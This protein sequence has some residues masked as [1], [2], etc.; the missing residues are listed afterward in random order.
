MVILK[1]RPA[2]DQRKQPHVE[3]HRLQLTL[4]PIVHQP[5][6]DTHHDWKV[7]LNLQVPHFIRVLLRMDDE[8]AELILALQLQDL[9]DVKLKGKGKGRED[10]DQSD[11]DLAIQL[12]KEECQQASTHI[13]DRRMARSI[14]RAVQDDGATVVVLASEENRAAADRDMACRLGGQTAQTTFR[15]PDPVPD[16]DTLSRF[17][18]F[19]IEDD[20]DGDTTTS[21]GFSEIDE[22][23]GSA[24]A[25]SRSTKRPYAEQRECVSCQDFKEVVAVPCQHLYCR[26]CVR[27]LFIDSTIDETLFPPRCCR[28]Q[29]PVSSVRHFLGSRLTAQFEKKA[30]E[31]GTLNRTYCWNPWCASFID[32]DCIRG[33]AGTCPRLGCGRQTCIFCKREAHSGSCSR[34]HPFEETIRLAQEAGWQRCQQCQ[35][36][37]E[38]GIGCNHIT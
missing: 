27:H 9:E 36:M 14:H 15:F 19:N 3:I 24:W 29:I 7:P 10:S 8:T 28:R 37:I 2:V 30:I 23:E 1:A 31:F 26:E 20:S 6:K 5:Y 16:D 21:V 17:S 12:Q 25:A 18:T 38:L 34:D 13:A 33:S 35:N 32:P 4:T 22:P 11:A